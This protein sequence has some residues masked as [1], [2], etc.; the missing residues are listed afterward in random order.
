M[1]ENFWENASR[2]EHLQERCWPVAF[3]LKLDPVLIFLVGIF[4]N[5]K[6]NWFLRT[7]ILWNDKN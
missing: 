3:F 2:R 1:V 7:E 5:F 4:R 6:K